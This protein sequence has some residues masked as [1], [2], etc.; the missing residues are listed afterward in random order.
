MEPTATSDLR[1]LQ[2][3]VMPVD[4]RPDVLPLYVDGGGARPQ[5]AAGSDATTAERAV[6]AVAPAD[7]TPTEDAFTMSPGEEGRRS[8]VVRAGRRVSFSTYFN[9]FPASY[10][11]R[12]TTVDEVLLRVRIRGEAVVSVYRSTPR[13]QSL[14]I[15]SARVDD[16]A[17]ARLEFSLPLTPFMDGGWYWFDITAGGRDATLEEADWSAVVDP[18][19]LRSGRLSIGITTFNRPDFCVEQLRDLGR[20]DD[21]MEVLDEIFVVDQG[22]RRVEDHP[23]FAEASKGVAGRLRVIEQGNLGGSGGFSRA[24]DET[25][26]ASGSRYVLLLDDDIVTE[27]EG[28]LR[29][30]AFADLARTPTIVGGHMFNLYDRSALHAFGETVAK[31]RWFWGPAPHTRHG[32]DLAYRSLRNTP[33]L[34]R[35]IDVDYNGWWM[36]LIPTDVVREVGLALP[37]FIKW[38]DAEYCLRAGAAGYPT[39]SMPGVAVWHVAWQDKDDALDWQAYFHRRNRI[40]SALLHSPYD[41]GGGLVRDSFEAQV[42]HLLCM[43]YST[44]EMGLTAIGDLLDGPERLHPDMMGKLAEVRELRKGFADAQTHGDVASF[45]PVRRRKPP[46]KEGEHARPD[47]RLT[48]LT[49]AALG[50]TR[51]ALPVRDLAR[52]HPQRAVPHQ[53]V[54]WSLLSKVDSAVVSTADGTGASWYKRDPERFRSLLHRSITVHA[55]LLREWPRLRERYR[56]ALPELTSPDRWRKTFETSNGPSDSGAGS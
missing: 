53:D 50:F 38:D 31:F 44:A 25:V 40:L 33:W 24:M 26:R 30:V 14:H 55:R 15:R 27:P 36:C 43:Q 54:H 49:L 51:Q 9:A 39:V 18:D 10:W 28:I 23:D 13:G 34:H 6:A 41:R 12:W 20:A 32:H 22:T 52:R 56:A 21:V 5:T 47:S 16:E 46:R 2:R 17:A 29:A 48:A 45:P 4:R 11:R 19:R 3:V 8:G 1:V 42:R 7:S 37:A 35:R